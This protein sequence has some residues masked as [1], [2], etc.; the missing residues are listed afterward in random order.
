MFK[1]IS[2]PG[3]NP[4]T[5]EQEITIA[6]S[7]TAIKILNSAIRSFEK[8]DR[9]DVKYVKNLEALKAELHIVWTILNPS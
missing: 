5:G 8:Y 2:D 9:D 7:N 3:K 6:V 4:N 1:P